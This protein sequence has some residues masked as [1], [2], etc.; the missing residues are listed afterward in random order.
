MGAALF[1][2]LAQSLS[3]IGSYIPIIQD[4][5]SVWLEI[6]PYLLTIIVLVLFIGNSEGPAANGTTYVK[7]K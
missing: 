6:A 2:G 1:F 7:S 4:I 5:P 3:V